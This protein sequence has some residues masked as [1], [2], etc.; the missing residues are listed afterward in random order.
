M[1]LAQK[2]ITRNVTISTDAY[3]DMLSRTA[4]KKA[5]A[6]GHIEGYKHAGMTKWRYSSVADER[7]RPTHLALHGKILVIGSQE[8]ALALKVL[9]EPNCRCR[10]VPFFDDEEMDTPKEAFDTERERWSKQAYEEWKIDKNIGF[11][12]DANPQSKADLQNLKPGLEKRMSSNDYKI[13]GHNIGMKPA[14]MADDVIKTLDENFFYSKRQEQYTFRHVHKDHGVK[15]EFTLN[16]VL[17]LRN[18]GKKP[19]EY[20]D[21]L[22]IIGNLDDGRLLRVAVSKDRFKIITAHIINKKDAENIL[23]KAKKVSYDYKPN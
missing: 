2:E 21:S 19:G 1:R 18:N 7:T 17:K 15:E 20:K 5:Y 8:E 14:D 10:P 9:G 11:L 4:T 16:D 13:L 23:Q 3:A 6:I 12:A 22:Q